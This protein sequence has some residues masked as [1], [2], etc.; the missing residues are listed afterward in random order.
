MR[1]TITRKFLIL[2]LVSIAATIFI[3]ALVFYDVLRRE[4]LIDLKNCAGLIEAIDLAGGEM[5]DVPDLRVTIIDRE[6]KALYD[7]LADTGLLGNH[8]ERPEVTAAFK[9]GEGRAIR[10]SETLGKNAFYY[11]FRMRNGN[12]VRVARDVSSMTLFLMGSFP[13]LLLLC[14]LIAAAS[15]LVARAL[16]DGILKPITSIANDPDAILSNGGYEELEPIVTAIKEQHELAFKDALRRQEFTANVSHE[17][18][19]P[20]AAI[21]GYAE[22][23]ANGMGDEE[24]IRK[25]GRDIHRNSERLLFLINDVIRLSELDSASE[26]QQDFAEVDLEKEAEMCCEM[27]SFQADK[28]KVAIFFEGKAAG[29]GIVRG[30]AQMLSELIYNLCDNAVRYNNPGGSV[31]VI[32]DAS[33]REVILKILDTGIGIPKEDQERIFERFYRVDKSRSR[34]TGGTGLGLAIVKHIVEQ[35]PGA[36]LAMKSEIG[37]GTAVEVHFPKIIGGKDVNL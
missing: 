21:S 11:A 27:L 1:R 17:L 32:V 13:L 34:E 33:E 31:R 23:V 28:R 16:T 36:Y 3:S 2:S 14:V 5:P 6:G 8:K 7:S 18:K 19:T 24:A 35:H 12:V 37:K 4:V 30:S 29:Q 25:Y 10:R 26:H 9:N 22:L 15:F 20:L